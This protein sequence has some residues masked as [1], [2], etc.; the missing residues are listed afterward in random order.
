MIRHALVE[1]L[2]MGLLLLV[3]IGLVAARPWR[4]EDEGWFHSSALLGAI[5]ISALLL[6]LM[7][8]SHSVNG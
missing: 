5:A 4:T 7:L 8:M 6:V 2:M 1:S 3:T